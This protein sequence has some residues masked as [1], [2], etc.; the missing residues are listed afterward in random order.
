MVELGLIL[1][2]VAP[3]LMA[4]IVVY[5]LVDDM[6]TAQHDLR[7]RVRDQVDKAASGSFRRIEATEKVR[8]KVPGQMH[9]FIGKK[10]LDVDLSL[11]SYGG[12]YQ[13]TGQS[14]FALFHRYRRITE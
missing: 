4:V 10:R 13:G 7:Y 12:T 3:L 5:N 8:I 11:S 1:I 6:I 9:R 14:E 2:L